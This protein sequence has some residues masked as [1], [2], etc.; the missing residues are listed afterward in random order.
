LPQKNADS[1]RTNL[2]IW[3]EQQTIRT[4]NGER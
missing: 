3:V 2:G 1:S 4:P